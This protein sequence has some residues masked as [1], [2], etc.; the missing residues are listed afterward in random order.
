[1]IRAAMAA[2]GS[3]IPGMREMLQQF[4]AAVVVA[5]APGGEIL[6]AN[7]RAEEMVGD[8]L[9]GEVADLRADV[10]LCA[11]AGRPLTYGEWPLVRC[12]TSGEQILDEE[13]V[14]VAA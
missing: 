4:P 13:A 2:Y 14:L 6:F 11:P 9:G 3:G 8:A 5:G 1:M 12:M 10:E 7:R